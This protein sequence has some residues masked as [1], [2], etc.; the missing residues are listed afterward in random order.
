DAGDGA[1]NLVCIDPT[2]SGDV[3]ATKKVWSFAKIGRSVSTVAVKDGLVFAA[4]YG[5]T[6][7]C[8][9]AETGK[10][11]WM[12]DCEAKIISSPLL[13]DGKLYVGNEQREL[14]CLAASRTK[15]VLGKTELDGTITG[16][17]LAVDGVLY[18]TTEKFLYAI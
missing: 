3:T 1:G 17:P 13:A 5:G 8:L 14:I 11:I 16:A 4:D 6:I 15:K 18:V 7:Y 12:H 9:D 10:Q 2:G